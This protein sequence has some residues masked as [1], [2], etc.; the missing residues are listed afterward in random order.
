MSDARDKLVLF[1]HA[2]NKLHWDCV[3]VIGLREL[4]GSSVQCSSESISNGPEASDEMR[5]LPAR[6]A[7]MVLCAQEGHDQQSPSDTS[8]GTSMHMEATYWA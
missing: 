2:I 3:G 7:M 6:E 8:P 5:S 1:S 4:S